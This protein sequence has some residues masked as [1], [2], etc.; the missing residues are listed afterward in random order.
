LAACQIG[1]LTGMDQVCVN[2]E[3]LHLVKTIKLTITR[4]EPQAGFQMHYLGL[5]EKMRAGMVDRP[6][7]TRDYLF[8]LFHSEVEVKTRDGRESW[9]A[10]SLMAWTPP[11]GH[12]YGNVRAPW[13]HS[14]FHCSG[15]DIGP[16]L[17]VCRFPMR[18][19]IPV[20]DP[21][22]MEHFLLHVIAELSGWNRIDA[23][24]LRNLFENFVRATMRQAFQK[25]EQVA[26]DR[27]LEIRSYLEQ[28]FTARIRLADLAR[29]AGWSEPHLCTEFRRY[30][31]IPII[32]F[33]LQL[34]MS[35]ANYLLRDQGR[36]VGEIAD[37]VG[38]PDLFT[39][40]KMFKRHFGISPKKFR[41]LNAQSR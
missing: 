1:H 40:S 39:F 22:V 16:I 3:Y 13:S 29:R 11:D 25:K 26:P 10:S 34:R 24:I 28:N 8:M 20:S 31:G 21:S 33:I 32:Q 5:H 35:Q 37:E 23:K 18:R 4:R 6:E 17:K 38:Y 7:G 2:L 14:W 36:R 30:F 41:E 15:R 27:L 9:P 12:Y 19:R